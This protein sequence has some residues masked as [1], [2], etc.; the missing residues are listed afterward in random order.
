MILG[1][2]SRIDPGRVAGERWFA[3]K[4][5][6]VAALTVEERFTLGGAGLAIMRADLTGRRAVRYTLPVGEDASMWLGLAELARL[7]GSVRGDAG[8]LLLGTPPARLAG[9]LPSRAA[10]TGAATTRASTVR[11]LGVDQSHTSMVVAEASVLK[12]YRR[13]EPGPSPEVELAMALAEAPIPAFEGAIRYVPAAA[14]DG[15]AGVARRPTDLAVVQ[16]YVPGAVDEFERLA[17]GLAAWL[18]VGAAAGG[19]SALLEVVSPAARTTAALHGALLGLRGPLGARAARPADISRWSARAARALAAAIRA[20]SPIDQA[21]AADLRASRDAIEAALAPIGHVLSG[22]PVARVHG[23]LHL[24]QL[25]RDGSRFLVVDFEGEPTRSLAARRRPDTPLRDVASMLRSFDH[26]AR[27]AT[28]RSGTT[29]HHAALEHWLETARRT[30][31]GAY[32]EELAKRGTAIELEPR[33]LHALEVEK[34]LYEFVYAATYL[35]AWR[36]AP[37]AGLRQ[38]LARGPG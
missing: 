36:Y 22:T 18:R 19:D 16:R 20:M 14:T 10:A 7:G 31:L 25:I 5:S 29:D 1:V 38:L 23:D 4:D 3:S 8:G 2:G 13:L 33:L 27:S 32:G 17:D 37:A 30:F 34:E 28:R 12:L 11:P 21:L 24:G 6:S 9:A 15:G 35:P 26:I